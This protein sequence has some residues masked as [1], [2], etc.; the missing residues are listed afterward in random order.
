MG[1]PD[2]AAYC[3]R[4]LILHKYN[5]VAVVSIPDKTAGRGLKTTSSAV[6]NVAKEF[7]LPLLQPEKLK[8]PDF[9]IQLSS[10]HA[11]IQVVVAFR[12]LPKEVWNMPVLGTFN[13]HASLLPNYRGAAPIQHAIMQGEEIT[14]VTTFLLD[15]KID[16]GHILFQ[17]E[18][19]IASTDNAGSLHD[20]LM[21]IGDELIRITIDNLSKGNILP[22]PQNT[23][24][25]DNLKE[26]PK[27]QK[28]DGKINWGES[29]EKI[30]LKV[31]GLTPFPGVFSELQIEDESTPIPI[32]IIET[33]ILE[34]IFSP[35]AE[36]GSV[37]SNFKDYMYVKCGDGK[38]IS[39]KTI[40]AAGKKQ[41]SI[42]EFLKGFQKF[43]DKQ[44]Q[45]SR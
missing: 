24:P 17:K 37:F 13:L 27:L 26:A 6:S 39:L 22:I 14:G 16:T 2:F 5:V 7:N 34:P 35:K 33:E 45:F 32:K 43:K 4:Q 12:M 44:M 29:A 20:K 11:D 36:S 3:L 41:L 10:F 19:P 38:Y 30:H 31:R 42:F 28:K 1:T 23:I 9:L 21:H 25:L 18:I 15:E 8:N 40:Q